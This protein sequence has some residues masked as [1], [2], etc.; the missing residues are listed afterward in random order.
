M[1]YDLRQKLGSGAALLGQDRAALSA[2]LDDQLGRPSAPSPIRSVREGASPPITSRVDA[3]LLLTQR[4]QPPAYILPPVI[5][6]AMASGQRANQSHVF[7][8][9][10]SRSGGSWIREQPFDLG[11]G[12]R[13]LKENETLG[14]PGVWPRSDHDPLNLAHHFYHWMTEL[15]RWGRRLHA[16]PSMVM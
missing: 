9:A 15:C 7:L 13:R 16:T 8:S 4:P 6:G 5:M 1:A 2:F 3:Q 10:Q 12:D 11:S 14:F